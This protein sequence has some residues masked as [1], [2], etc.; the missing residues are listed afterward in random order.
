MYNKNTLYWYDLE[1][2]G[3]NPKYNRI[4]QFAGVRTDE[5]LNIIAEPLV[6]YCKLTGDCLPDPVSCLITGITPQY[7]LEHG[8][9][10]CEF[11]AR[12]HQELSRPNT[13]IVGY[14]N[15][16]FD[17]EFIRYS[18]YRNFFDPYEHE[19]KNGNSRWDIMDIVR[20]TKA[21]RPGGISWPLHA[22]GSPSFK[23]EDLTKANKLPHESAHDA[24]SDV[25][26]TIAVAQKISEKQPKL[27]Q[28]MFN[29]RQKK[30]VLGLLSLANPKPIVHISA[31]YPV[32][33]GCTA[34]VCPIAS[35]PVNK[36]G[37]IVFDLSYDPLALIQLTVEEIRERLFTP[38]QQLPMG[39]KRIPLKTVHINKCPVVVPLNTLD[40][41]SALRLK[42]DIKKCSE[43]F[44]LLQ[45]AKELS[46]KIQNVFADQKFAVESDPDFSLYSGFFSNHDKAKFENIRNATP[47]QLASIQNTFENDKIPEMLFRYRARNYPE[48][49]SYD[50]RKQWEK[51]RL[52]RLQSETIDFMNLNSYRSEIISLKA[53]KTLEKPQLILLEELLEYARQLE[54]QGLDR[55]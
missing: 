47:S 52:N 13:C 16:R 46:N 30:N 39:V 9:R 18:L 1:T 26:A 10:E 31:M 12:I 23:L 15:I 8:V 14:N 6:I 29:M 38:T 32:E 55:I 50:E 53:S 17:D 49:L 51:F 35:H 3:T 45:A 43:N 33:H 44:Q 2:F 22:D 24:L 25:Y 40:S 41:E 19:W 21:L 11:I 7:S 28:Y 54:I 48:S 27:Y 4:V 37:I 42:I 36:N 5:H 20:L 34:V